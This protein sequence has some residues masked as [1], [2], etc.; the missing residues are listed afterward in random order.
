MEANYEKNGILDLL[1]RPGFCVKENKIIQAN[2]AAQGLL[3]QPGM[4]VR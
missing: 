4:D 3:L 2:A 1:I